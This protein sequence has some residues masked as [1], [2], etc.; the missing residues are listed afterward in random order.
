MDF[1]KWKTFIFPVDCAEQAGMEKQ[2]TITPN[3][4]ASSFKDEVLESSA[5]AENHSDVEDL[6]TVNPVEPPPLDW[7]SDSSSE[8]SSL[9]DFEEPGS[10]SVD[11]PLE[12]LRDCGACN[13]SCTSAEVEN[14]TS[15]EVHELPNREVEDLTNQKAEDSTN[16]AQRMNECNDVPEPLEKNLGKTRQKPAENFQQHDIDH[17]HIQELLNQLQLFHPTPP[18]KDPTPEPEPEKSAFSA[19]C[20]TED[21]SSSCFVPDVSTYQTCPDGSTASGLLFTVSHQRELLE[22]LEAPEPKE[23]QEFQE[24]QEDHPIYTEQTAETQIGNLSKLPDC[25]TRY[26]T[27]SCEADEMVAVSYGSDIWHSPFDE[28]MMTGYT[29]DEVM[30]QSKFLF[31]DELASRGADVV[32]ET[33]FIVCKVKPSKCSYC[34][35]F[36]SFS[37]NRML[38]QMLRLHIKVVGEFNK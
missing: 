19:D 21:L 5:Q 37:F 20:A 11:T 15:R 38:R 30:E 22:L 1:D 23:T 6:D 4:M 24:Y 35:N 10:V 34:V 29:N 12:E 8:V 32:G 2:A 33:L 9:R 7:R 28:F 14:F 17:S 26:I 25:Q 3:K 16:N 27:R 31:S 18:S 13:T 36:Y